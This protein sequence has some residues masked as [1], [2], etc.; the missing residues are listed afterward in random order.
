MLI[1]STQRYSKPRWVVLSI[2]YWLLPSSIIS[3]WKMN[4]QIPFITLV[5][6]YKTFIWN[7]FNNFFFLFIGKYFIC[8]K[9]IALVGSFCHSRL[10]WKS[11]WG[12]KKRLLEYFLSILK[13]C[14]CYKH[15]ANLYPISLFLIL[16]LLYKYQQKRLTI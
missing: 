8:F 9:L 12:Y 10:F 7:I 15:N 2:L 5:A 6:I 11:N 3:V 13:I 4:S 16:V 14:L 1:F